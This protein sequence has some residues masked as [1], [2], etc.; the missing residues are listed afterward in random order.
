MIARIFCR[1]L[2]PT[3]LCLRSLSTVQDIPDKEQADPGKFGAF[4]K[5]AEEIKESQFMN[6]QE[7]TNNPPPSSETT[8]EFHDNEE[9]EECLNSVEEENK[10][11]SVDNELK[12]EI[13]KQAM[14]RA[15]KL[16]WTKEALE[17]AAEDV[18]YTEDI[19]K[20]FPKAPI[21]LLDYASK[22]W[23]TELEQAL[24]DVKTK[25]Q[26]MDHTDW[27]YFGLSFI[28]KKVT[29]YKKCSWKSITFRV[30]PSDLVNGAVALNR[31]FDLLY[32]YE[33]DWSIN[34]S[35]YCKRINLFAIYS[36]TIIFMMFDESKDNEET[37]KFL[38]KQLDLLVKQGNFLH[39]A[40]LGS[41][42]IPK[43]VNGIFTT[44]FTL[45]KETMEMKK[46]P[47]L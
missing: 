40:Y 15:K 4:F 26:L 1:V 33:G 7:F 28:L 45:L 17:S 19:N 25:G 29:A 42:D 8:T 11:E 16:G 31:I 24:E 2:R 12:G 37:F 30:H 47:K 22:Q 21:E 13:L 35:Y 10:E 6:Q 9:E 20:L 36:R 27:I 34:M 38:R 5:V 43:V 23:T 14:Q 39:W 41:Y 18:G 32:R 46:G 3:R 44:L